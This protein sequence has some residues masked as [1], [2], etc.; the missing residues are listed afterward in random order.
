MAVQRRAPR[1]LDGGPDR[2]R[3]REERRLERPAEKGEP[4]QTAG[5]GPLREAAP[6]VG[7]REREEGECEKRPRCEM[8]M[9]RHRQEGGHGRAQ[10]QQSGREPP[11]ST[12]APSHEHREDRNRGRRQQRPDQRPEAG[13][14]AN[15]RDCLPPDPVE[16]T[17]RAV[18]E[19]EKQRRNALARHCEARH[20]V[21]GGQ[22]A[23]A[24][25]D[26][27][28]IVGNRQV[29]EKDGPAEARAGD[30]EQG[31]PEYSQPPLALAQS[32]HPGRDRSGERSELCCVPVTEQQGRGTEQQRV[33][34]PEVQLAR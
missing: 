27:I 29:Q 17:D 14:L 30:R 3:R 34:Q 20:D 18:L 12:E 19:I 22:D 7:S 5:Q 8:R 16:A 9:R 15:R 2:D 13:Q 10:E 28:L 6:A 24:E 32:A 25:V 11:G 23:A 26:R 33:P 4:K 21:P 1:G 31:E